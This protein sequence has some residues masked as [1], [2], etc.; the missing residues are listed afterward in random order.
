LLTLLI[1]A[2][3]LSCIEWASTRP[4]T[5]QDA[6]PADAPLYRIA[7]APDRPWLHNWRLTTDVTHAE[8]T[9]IDNRIGR[10][11]DSTSN[12]AKVGIE[13]GIGQSGFGRIEIGRS[14]GRNGSIAEFVR[15]EGDSKTTS[16]GASGG[17]FVLP[18]LAVG[19]MV[20][21]GWTHAEDDFSD[22]G[23][24]TGLAEVHRDDRQL[25]WAP[26]VMAIYP[27]GPVELSATG[28]Y[29]NIERH[30]DYSGSGATIDAD[31]GDLHAVTGHADIGWWIV[32]ELRIGGGVT[33]IDIVEQTPQTGA[34]PL[35]DSWGNVQGNMLWRTPISGVDLALHGGQDFAN[36]QGDGWSVGGGLAFR[37]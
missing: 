21:Y 19:G 15:D 13:A 16:L 36:R 11:G 33:W 14:L 9:D 27:I 24:G 2:A 37:F 8:G 4:A 26:F 23:T 28:S 10:T 12:T 5:A 1:G 22:P 31:S 17:V 20:Q 29:F 7:P 34:R 25:K 32:P 30:S 3:L 6:A 18:F 35:D